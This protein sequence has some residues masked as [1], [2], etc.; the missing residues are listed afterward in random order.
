MNSPDIAAQLQIQFNH[1]KQLQLSEGI[2]DAATR[3]A[4][5]QR[6]IDL[7]V[8]H[9]Q[10]FAAALNE[11]FAGRSPNLSQLTEIMTGVG[12]FKHAIKNLDK[13][14]KAEKRPAPFPM[15]LLGSRTEIRYQPKGVI[16]IMSPWNFPIAMV[17][18]PLCNALAAG[19]RAIIKP[20]EFNPK[21]AELI[22]RLLGEYFS[23]DVVHVITGGPEAG[24]AFSAIP[25]DHILFTGATTIG[26]KVMEAAAQ[27][28][29]PVT[30]E[31][32]GKSPVIVEQDYPIELAA[33]RIISGKSMN[34]GQV[35]I[36][37]DYVFVPEAGL[38]AFISTAREVFNTQFPKVIGNPD[39]TAVVNDRHY[40]RIS[41]YLS[42]AKA[43][44]CRV[45]ALS[46]DP[47]TEGDRRIPLHLI[48]NPSDDLKIMQ[49]E[50]FGP[51]MV[52]K[53]YRSV[54]DCLG[55][56]N[57]RPSPLAFYYFGNDKNRQQYI[58]D[59]TLSGGVTINNVTMHVGSSDLPFG[60]VGDSGMGNYHGI[61][62]FKTFSHARSV[63]RQ[64]K[65]DLAKVAG[66]LPPYTDKIAK[67]LDSQI[68][69]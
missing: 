62:G 33:E 13:W 21:T 15:G 58:L 27:N 23:S 11:D 46:A 30:L 51:L 6:C 29:T 64:G 57:A 4:R 34:S 2:P 35:C 61:E 18:N 19:N 39:Y 53:T 54:E 63:F 65:L 12:H 3:K 47:L 67:M 38:E 66:T 41:G 32:G 14:M 25:F 40:Q 55:Y 42:E 24:A 44:G 56:I 10:D 52:V 36:S 49:D 45:E 16:G 9:R 37:P 68:K 59:N 26:K 20:S 7:M 28:L 60:G 43:A 5:L 1:M 31:L 48:V 50:I 22:K 17:F 69:K 8:D